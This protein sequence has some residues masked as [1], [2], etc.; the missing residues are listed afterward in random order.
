[1]AAGR[2]YICKQ[3][4][5]LG[6]EGQHFPYSDSSA[7]PR[8]FLLFPTV[9]C[10]LFATQVGR[11]MAMLDVCFPFCLPGSSLF[12]VEFYCFFVKN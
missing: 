9:P 10:I 2:T 8:Y 4:G 7:K 6:G 11:C 5:A 3:G 1:M 12:S